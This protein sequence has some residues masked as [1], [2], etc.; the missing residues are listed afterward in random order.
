MGDLGGGVDNADN[1]VHFQYLLGLQIILVRAV[2]RFWGRLL[3]V[4]RLRIREMELDDGGD[5]G[6]RDLWRRYGSEGKAMIWKRRG[7][8]ALAKSVRHVRNDET[9]GWP[10]MLNYNSGNKVTLHQYKSVTIEGP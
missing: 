5:L 8:R 3:N 1:R 9:F 7:L 6:N 2:Q 10:K 4:D